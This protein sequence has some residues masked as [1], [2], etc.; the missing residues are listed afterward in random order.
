MKEFI[1]LHIKG[2]ITEIFRTA[3]SKQR[4]K[5]HLGTPLYK[6]ALFLIMKSG[7][8]AILGFIFWV[9]VARFYS[10]SEVGVASAL[11]SAMGLLT[12]L[13]LL[14]VNLGLIRFLPGEQ[15]R[16]GMINSSLTI[17]GAFSLL[18]AGIFILGLPFWSPALL[19]LQENV[20]LIFYFVI[21]VTASSLY[22]IQ[23]SV[24]IALRFTEAI[25]IRNLLW[26]GFKI[27]LVIAL[28]SWGVLGIFN[29]WGI[30]LWI[31]VIIS[32]RF[33]RKVQP[34][35]RPLP[36]IK[37][38][39]LNHMMRFSAGNYV[40]DMLSAAPTYM[41]P[42]LVLGALGA[43]LNAY[44]YIAFAIA[45]LL[46]SIPVA[47]NASLFAE[48]SYAPEKLRAN[49]IRA[50]KFMLLILIPAII[51]VLLLGDKILLL[52]GVKYSQNALEVLQV[53]SI[54]SIPYA[55]IELYIVVKRIQ[56]V[57]KPIIYTCAFRAV[58]IPATCY[59]LI[60][61]VGLAGV[62]IGWT[63]GQGMVAIIVG[64]IMARELF[65]RKRSTSQ[66][67]L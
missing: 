67:K 63:L 18:L 53:L 56:L 5:V 4:L 51:A 41:L 30:A 39:V 12:M 31:A 34:D 66:A 60:Q 9:V 32:I 35:Y 24:F 21:F 47:V 20:W 6:N 8:G 65:S 57:I 10:T 33:I 19:F 14:G 43:E 27:A 25:F 50:T 42:L 62:G 58:L 23:T 38:S 52:F 17:V 36:T 49:A 22:R 16:K 11:I 7:S 26:M 44:F 13:S 29:S 15:D 37:K 48:G 3:T 28:T 61:S 54:S 64:V 40:A 1:R 2:T 46:F 59:A 55:L 45:N